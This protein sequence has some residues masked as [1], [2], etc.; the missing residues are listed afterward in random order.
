MG[1][2]NLT[3]KKTHLKFSMSDL[4][5]LT[6]EERLKK[7]QDL[8]AKNPQRIPAII[9]IDD[10]MTSIQ[11]SKQKY[12]ISKK[13]TVNQLIVFLEKENINDQKDK[14]ASDKSKFIMI[15]KTVLKSTDLMSDVYEKLKHQDGFLY[16]VLTENAAMGE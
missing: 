14:G 13:F 8:V 10:S 16:L 7:S 1:N 2:Y 4:K 3:N 5:N 9:V 12:L 11:L 6:Q 15:N